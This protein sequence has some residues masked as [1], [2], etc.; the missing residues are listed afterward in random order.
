MDSKDIDLI[1]KIIEAALVKYA[2]GQVPF[3]WVSIIVSGLV[4]GYAILWA[5]ALSKDKKVLEKVTEYSTKIESLSNAQRDRD[6]ARDEATRIRW[7]NVLG[8]LS[9]Q[10][11]AEKSKWN[12]REKRLEDSRDAAKLQYE[13][14]LVAN[15]AIL[16]KQLNDSNATVNEA[17]E[18]F[19][20]IIPLLQK[21]SGN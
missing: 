5:Y 2:Q 14:T 12:T 21:E 15:G 10:H 20:L 18:M 16:A 13:G 9:S 8:N 19:E 11:D 1:G 7:E 6:D 3:L 17:T 4:S